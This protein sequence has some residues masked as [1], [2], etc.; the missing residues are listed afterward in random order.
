MKKRG[1][2][3][4][5]A[6]LKSL[7]NFGREEAALYRKIIRQNLTAARKDAGKIRKLEAA[8]P[9]DSR[10]AFYQGRREFHLAQADQ[11]IYSNWI[12]G[13]SRLHQELAYAYMK[14]VATCPF[15][16]KRRTADQLDDMVYAVGKILDM[17]TN[18]GFEMI[19][20]WMGGHNYVKN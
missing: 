14:G 5:V 4:M 1:S 9:T 11:W 16:F 13:Q 6:N 12:V 17:D 10:I 2:R 18:E 3:E 19:K 15:T 7:V 8:D 20:A